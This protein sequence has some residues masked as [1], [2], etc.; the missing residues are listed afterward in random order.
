ML[1]I[2]SVPAVFAGS[3]QDSVRNTPQ[4]HLVL[5][6][7]NDSHYEYALQQRQRAPFE[8]VWYGPL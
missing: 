8:L 3:L 1:T 2:A 6:T 5:G 7:A 4:R